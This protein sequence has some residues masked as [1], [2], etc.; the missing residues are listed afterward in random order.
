LVRL[1]LLLL[2]GPK[3]RS[4]FV[5]AA[6]GR[7]ASP[8]GGARLAAALPLNLALGLVRLFQT[9]PDRMVSG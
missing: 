8:A 1:F 4:N 2:L 6:C 3:P 9:I 7:L 5:I